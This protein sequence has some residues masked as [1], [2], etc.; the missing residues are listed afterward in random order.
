M[1]DN[2]PGHY[3]CVL[4]AQP[5]SVTTCVS[6]CTVLFC[7]AHTV[8]SL[9]SLTVKQFA[10]IATERGVPKQGMP[11]IHT[12]GSSVLFA[13]AAEEAHTREV[14]SIIHHAAL[15]FATPGR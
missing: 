3:D 2:R 11:S 6:C 1:H 14:T 4:L 9:Q 10:E 12:S 7:T 15:A 5:V 13:A 8:L